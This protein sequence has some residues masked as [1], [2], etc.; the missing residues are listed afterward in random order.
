[1]P[2]KEQ[3]YA[4]TESTVPAEQTDLVEGTV[5]TRDEINCFCCDLRQKRLASRAARIVMPQGL[6]EAG[7]VTYFCGKSECQTMADNFDVRHGKPDSVAE[8]SHLI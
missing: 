3:D 4:M 2:D 6:Y 7:A 8:Y 5:I 1:M